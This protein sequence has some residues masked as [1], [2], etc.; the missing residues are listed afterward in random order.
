MKNLGFK[1]LVVSSFSLNESSPL[2]QALEAFSKQTG[3]TLHLVDATGSTWEITSYEKEPKSL[4]EIL[5]Q[6]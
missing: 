3:D 4:I 6:S 1:L 2:R 5:R